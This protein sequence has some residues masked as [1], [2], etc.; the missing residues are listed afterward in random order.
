MIHYLDR[1]L[2][3]QRDPDA[4]HGARVGRLGAS[5]VAN[6]AYEKSADGYA[7][8]KMKPNQYTGSLAMSHGHLREAILLPQLGWEQNHLMIG[9]EVNNRFSATPDGINESTHRL[10]QMK[11]SIHPFGKKVQPKHLRQIY[12]EQF[13]MGPDWRETDLI[14]EQYELIIGA[15]GDE[16]YVPLFDAPLVVT[17]PRDDEAILTLVSISTKVLARMDEIKDVEVSW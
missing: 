4:W 10:A 16:H 7:I 2:A 8:A 3:D 1:V 13:V 14:F 12:W 17:I 9:S 6:F 15:D 11:T 5:D